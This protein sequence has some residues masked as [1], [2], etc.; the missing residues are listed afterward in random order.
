MNPRNIE[1]PGWI[2]DEDCKPN[3]ICTTHFGTNVHV[4][5][6]E[7]PP[8]R[9]TSSFMQESFIARRVE[10][11]GDDPE[12]KSAGLL[13][14][15]RLRHHRIKH[16]GMHDQKKT[17]LGVAAAGAFRKLDAQSRWSQAVS[18]L[19]IDGTHGSDKRDS[20]KSLVQ[21]KSGTEA[22]GKSTISVGRRDYQNRQEVLKLY[23]G[24]ALD[25]FHMGSTKIEWRQDHGKPD[26]DTVSWSAETLGFVGN[27][28]AKMWRKETDPEN[29]SD[30]NLPAL[31]DVNSKIQQCWSLPNCMV[32]GV[33]QMIPEPDQQPGQKVQICC[34]MR[35]STP[36]VFRPREQD[37]QKKGFPADI[38]KYFKIVAN[39]EKKTIETNKLSWSYMT[40]EQALNDIDREFKKECRCKRDG[41]G[42]GGCM[43]SLDPL[44]RKTSY[45]CYV[46]N[47]KAC[48][49]QANVEHDFDIVIYYSADGQPWTKQLCKDECK[50]QGRGI[51]FAEEE[52]IASNAGIWENGANFGS[53]CKSWTTTD[54]HDWCYV[55]IDSTCPDR[56]LS[57][58]RQGLNFQFYWSRVACIN[59][60]A[61]SSDAW[62]FRHFALPCTIVT[63][64]AWMLQAV[65][66]LLTPPMVFMTFKY[67]NNRC[68]DS[69]NQA[70]IRKFSIESTD[71]DEFDY[72]ESTTT[73][74]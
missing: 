69:I 38:A 45:W 40:R 17:L 1:E 2:E 62:L 49:E 5:Y 53:S 13:S 18:T 43:V 4:K 48:E 65:M 6:T 34:F 46:E 29:L 10:P 47:V 7:Q 32:V 39:F 31:V 58:E 15:N 52:S 27:G 35:H 63:S 11:R 19:K 74:M 42:H 55:G 12:P 68:G 33:A 41:N 71:E 66:M 56:R 24:G 51:P 28:L 3:G 20:S 23:K 8:M 59:Q 54:S 70:E 14:T 64:V 37:S 50:C 67:V 44:T 16:A 9:T 22:I 26:C 30:A 36:T 73:A 60:D 61:Q 57:Q 25:T 21:Y 72:T